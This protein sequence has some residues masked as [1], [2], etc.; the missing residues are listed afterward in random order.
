[1]PSLSDKLKSLGVKVGVQDLPK[2]PPRNPYSIAQ[3][4]P[5]RF[6]DTPFGEIFIAE[7]IYSQDYHHGA[8]SL[9][10]SS[11]LATIAAWAGESRIGECEVNSFAYLD[12]ETTGLSGGTGTYAFLIGVGR[13]VGEDFHL[14]QYFMADPIEEPAQLA[15][16]EKFLAPCSTLV[17]FNGKAF[18]VPIL[19][20]RFISQGWRTPLSSFSHLDL[21]PLARRLWR[22]RLPSRTLGNLEAK[23]LQAIRSEQDIPGW[24]IPQ[25]YFE[26]LHTRDARPLRSIFYHNA[27]DVLGMAALLNHISFLLDDPLNGVGE[28]SLD[29]VAIAR[30]NEDL[31]DLATAIQLYNH[32][33]VQDLPPSSHLETLRR[34]SFL[35]KRLGNYTEAAELW[36]RAAEHKQVYAMVELAKLYEHRWSD[37]GEA[38][39]WTKF[40]LD[41][42]QSTSFS[43]LESAEWQ[44]QLEHRL[45]R[46]QRKNKI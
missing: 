36:R 45:S 39:Y 9:K 46:L 23:I 18:D 38:T 20:A 12:T 3:V 21:L 26:Y 32:C 13:F 2:P 14:A 40:A 41:L 19:N 33:L 31:G 42:V 5:G 6:E 35:N 7:S 44:A 11:S 43:S 15:A 34:L 25:L 16:L 27:M 17:T 24:M 8:Y 29:L 37:I 10:I 28:H 1:M 30:L 22:D 4:I